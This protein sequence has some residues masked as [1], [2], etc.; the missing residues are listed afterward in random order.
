LERERGKERREEEDDKLTSLVF[1][2]CQCLWNHRMG[3]ESLSSVLE[4]LEKR[5]VV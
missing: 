4:D 2:R 1:W 3:T 5:D